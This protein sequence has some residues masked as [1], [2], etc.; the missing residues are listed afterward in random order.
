MVMF[1]NEHL[2]YKKGFLLLFILM[3]FTQNSFASEK[4]LT[5][6]TTGDYQPVTWLD[7]KT[8]QY[9][10]FDIDMARLIAQKLHRQLVFVKTT[11]K[12]LG[13]DLKD[14][15]FDVAMGGITVTP[16]REKSFIFST[17]VLFDKKVVV[18]RCLD[19]KKLAVWDE[20]KQPSVRLI[21]NRGGTNEIF[22]QQQAKQATLIIANNNRTIFNAI[23]N[24]Q[25]DAMI[26]DRLEANY[27]HHQH[28]ALCV[29]NIPL[30]IAPISGKA[31]ML[32]KE[33]GAL[34]LAINN[35]IHEM[36]ANHGLQKLEDKWDINNE[37][38]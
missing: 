4:V 31:Y 14:K 28:P 24:N 9:S 23:M 20:I 38:N 21:E 25:A 18:I 5:V 32:R 12:T 34:Q 6:G 13:Q 10:G 37:Y 26:T 17:P 35:V 33:E 15:K 11:W 2:F 16:E 1:N 27:Q 7:E 30:K 36:K 29:L 8:G 19:E 22:A 3:L